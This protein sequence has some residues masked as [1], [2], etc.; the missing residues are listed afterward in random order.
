VKL[1]DDAGNCKSR[2]VCVKANRQV[3]I[4]MSEDGCRGEEGF[5]LVKGDLTFGEPVEA[6]IL[7]QKIGDWCKV[8]VFGR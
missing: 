8:L 7:L 4:E 6:F 1:V 3:R 2:S 5:E